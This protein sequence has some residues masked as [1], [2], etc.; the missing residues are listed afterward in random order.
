MKEPV[1]QGRSD[2][3]P[4]R[5]ALVHGDRQ[6]QRGQDGR[7]RH[8]RQGGLLGRQVDLCL[9]DGAT[10][11]SV[12]EAKADQARPA[13]PGRRDLRRDLQLDPAGDQGAAV[14]EGQEAL[15]LPRAVRRAGMRPAHLL[16][17]PGAGAAGRAADPL[18]DAE[19]RGEEILPA[20]GRL[21]LAARAEQE[22]SVRWSRP[23]A[24]RSS[25]RSISRSITPTTARRSARS[26][27]SGAEV[28]FNTIVPPGL[29]PF[30]EQLHNSGFTKRG[31]Q[32]VCTYFDENFL[33]LVPAAHVEGLYSC[34]DY[35]QNVSDPV[36]QGAARPVQQ[37]LSGQRQVHRRQRLLGPVPRP[38]AL[39]GRGER[40]GLAEA[41]RRHQGARPRQDRRG[42]RRSGRNGARPASRSHEH[43][44]RPGE[45]RPV[46]DR[47]EPRR[48]SI[49][50]N[51]VQSLQ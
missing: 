14:V 31:G 28:V 43:V 46:R 35:Y 19:D 27:A 42:A 5:S 18:A 50:R 40:G 37:A 29:T 24:A 48:T 20:V 10:T 23:T 32:L 16:H 1:H 6:R 22:A 47:Q 17:R 33:N 13:R 25:A 11:D 49:R 8:Q 12:A 9:E 7:R 36:Q 38:E 34:L 21:H 51:P 41:G 4:D 3:R 45:E 30:L 26:C 15:H 44:H 2:R 39:G